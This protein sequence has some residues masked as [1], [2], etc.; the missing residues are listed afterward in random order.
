[1]RISRF[2]VGALS[3]VPVIALSAG[4]VNPFWFTSTPATGAATLEALTESDS[5]GTLV[6]SHTC[7][8]PSGI[9]SGELLQIVAMADLADPVPPN[10]NT[11]SG[12][13]VKQID[14]GTTGADTSVAVWWLEATGSEGNVTVTHNAAAAYMTCAYM[15]ISDGDTEV[16]YDYITLTQNQPSSTSFTNIGGYF[17]EDSL[18]FSV[19]AFDGGDGDPF[20]ESGTGWTLEASNE[21][22]SGGGQGIGQAISTNPMT[23]A[24][25]SEDSV[26]ASTVADSA[27][28]FQWAITAT[29]NAHGTVAYNTHNAVTEEAVLDLTLTKPTISVGDTAI[30][31]GS[32][33][34]NIPW[35]TP[36]GWQTIRN[37]NNLGC[38]INAAWRLIDGTEGATVDFGNNT[39][40]DKVG[41]YIR[42][43]GANRVNPFDN[44]DPDPQGAAGTV[45]DIGGI[46]TTTDGAMAFYILGYDGGDGSPFSITGGTGWTEREDHTTGGLGGDASMT[47]GTKPVTSMGATGDVEITSSGVGDGACAYI[48]TIKP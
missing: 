2:F 8:A 37:S 45:H 18:A 19:L 25:V 24:G 3:L 4:L 46:D 22:G 43:T 10:W 6:T 1:M 29:G 5:G 35:T 36:A 13:W 40:G 31:V 38:S 28:G 47:W 44:Y 17:S 9:T 21:S 27:V 39:S 23:A 12:G 15:R 34:S 32:D 16:P 41:S 30:L 14:K 33:M 11:P 20:T 7:T 48:F 26:F 42:I